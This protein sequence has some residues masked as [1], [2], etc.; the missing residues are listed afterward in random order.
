MRGEATRDRGDIVDALGGLEDGVDQDR[1]LDAVLGLELGQKLIE[2]M[3]VPCA[4]DL[5]QH[6]DVELLPDR[7]RRSRVMSSSTQGELSALMRVHNPVS[8]KSQAFAMA[9]KPDARGFLGVGGDGVLEI[10]EH[11]VDLSDQLRHFGAHFLDMRRHE[12]NHA[13]EPQRQFA[14]WRRSADRQRLEE[15]TRQFHWDDPRSPR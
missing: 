3:D 13:F 8:P 2:I 12:V 10:A 4:L 7:R 1:L 5:R 14:Q 11:H 15:I 6:D 9:M